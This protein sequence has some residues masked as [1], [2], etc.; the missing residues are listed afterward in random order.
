MKP[1]DP[2]QFKIF[3]R[4]LTARAGAIVAGNPPTSR[5]ES[6]VANCFPGLELDHRNLDRRFFPGLIFDFNDGGPRNGGLLTEVDVDDPDLAIPPSQFEGEAQRLARELAQ[7]APTGL[8][9]RAGPWFLAIIEQE[10]RRIEVEPALDGNFVWRLVQCLE[11]GAV[12]IGLSRRMTGPKPGE[13]I[14]LSGWRRNFTDPE[15]GVIPPVYAAG[16]LT[17]SMCS[18]WQHDFRDCS[19]NYWASNHPDIVLGPIDPGAHVS[20]A[21]A[22]TADD[23][24]ID[25]L[26]ADRTAPGRV[27]ALGTFDLN[28]PAQLD[29]FEIN[30]RWQE[31]A[32]VLRGRE[33]DQFYAPPSA[34][35]AKPFAD[36]SDLAKELRALAGLEHVLA[37]EYLYAMSSVPETPT[38]ADAKKWPTLGD[39]VT[40]VRHELLTI[41]VS[42][43]RHLRWVNQILWS[44]RHKGLVT[45]DDSPALNLATRVPDGHG[46]PRARRLCM[47]TP[48]VLDSFVR[49]EEPSG[50]LEGEYARVLAT[51]RGPEYLPDLYEIAAHV[52]AD[53]VEHYARFRQI[54]AT[55]KKYVNATP[56][57][58]TLTQARPNKAK[59]A[60][61]LYRRIKEHLGK[62]YGRGDMEQG[63]DIADARN[64]M[65]ELLGE[66]ETI[67]GTGKGVPFFSSG[68]CPPPQPKV[69]SRSAVAERERSTPRRRR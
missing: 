7:D 20:A 69:T 39:D 32:F 36:A 10:G 11:P 24:R 19:C 55:L 44:L 26:R 62:A 13:T 35:Y 34:Q 68:P 37:L 51:L 50:T 21:G 56:Y 42:E 67:A 38:A 52:I 1:I 18:P 16:E 30:G 17:Q 9:L 41:A 2:T 60:L 57:L 63:G 46:K 4:N 49:V 5:P 59:T 65:F 61:D 28:R 12:R 23:P 58:R 66:M 25:W 3:P 54:R 48:A 33:I 22:P 6:G 27:P 45:D 29:H 15:S 47:L 64:L 31:L 53:G 40:F 14:T 43:M 8:R